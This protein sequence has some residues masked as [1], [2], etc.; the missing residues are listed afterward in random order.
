M[1]CMSPCPCRLSLRP[2]RLL[3]TSMAPKPI[4]TPSACA[5][6]ASS[7]LPRCPPQKR[8]C[9]SFCEILFPSA[10]GLPL[11]TLTPFFEEHLSIHSHHGFRS[12]EAAGR[13]RRGMVRRPMM[14]STCTRSLTL[15][16]GLPFSSACSW[17]SVVSST[18]MTPVPSL[19]FWPW[20]TSRRSLLPPTPRRSLPP[21]SLSSSLFSRPVP[22]SVP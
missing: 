9:P 2:L 12:P 20:T 19:V 10:L 13:A 22:S 5:P 8:L 1:A 15:S 6:D 11:K 16:A 4:S 3:L 21:R 17:P 18:D 14:L 7:P